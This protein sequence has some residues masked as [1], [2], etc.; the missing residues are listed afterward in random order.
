M[1]RRS[2]IYPRTRLPAKKGFKPRKNFYTS[3][4]WLLLRYQAIKACGRRCLLCHSEGVE[5]HVDHIKPRSKYPHLAYELS[6]L[7]VLCR[8]C[9]KGKSNV[10]E[11]DW[12]NR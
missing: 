6:N 1:Y 12:R 3:K 4:K 9:N 8:W 11:T 7:Q 2:G 5:L 10:D